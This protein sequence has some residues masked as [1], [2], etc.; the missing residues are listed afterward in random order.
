M[1]PTTDSEPFV[2]Y[3][4]RVREHLSPGEVDYMDAV[5][6]FIQAYEEEHVTLDDVHGVEML[7]AL[8]EMNDLKQTDLIAEFGSAS[9]VSDVI[10]GRR[11]VSKAVIM[12]LAERYN[13]SPEV[14]FPKP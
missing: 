10:N 8:M 2:S 14:F 11:Q 12:K 5:S 1:T 3:V 4:A 7:K 13:V 9:L 6:A